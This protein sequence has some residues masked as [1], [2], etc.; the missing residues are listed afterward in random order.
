MHNNLLD[1][2]SYE[3]GN[4]ILVHH[5]LIEDFNS[6]SQLIVNESQEALFYKEGQALDLFGPGRH[7]LSTSN[8]PLLRKV[9]GALFGGNTPY[10]CDV[11][12]INKVCVMDI[13]WGTDSPIALEDPKYQLLI[14][15][16]ANGSMALYVEDSR[17]FVVN[18][19]GQLPE[20]GVDSVK[21]AIK[22]A[23]MSVIKNSIATAIASEGISILEVT[24]HLLELGEKCLGLVNKELEFFGLKLKKFYINSI[25]CPDEDLKELKEMKSKA[26]AMVIEAGAKAKSREIQGYD[27]RTERQFDVLD[28]AASNTGGAAGAFVGAGVG[29]G[30][31][32]GVGTAVSG[33]AKDAMTSQPQAAGTVKC[34]KCGAEIPA[35]AKFCPNCGQENKPQAHFC[36]NC[37]NKVEAGAKF[38]PNC[39][40]KLGE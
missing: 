30:V 29:L 7:T 28:K 38:C 21:K 27:Y 20:Y 31:G 14:N 16:R 4:D 19:V 2:I 5:S 33:V 15:V 37:G 24:T 6:K 9:V 22:G 35:S 32:V 34:A 25:S 17:R 1:V 13:M 8:L 26:T 36:P 40:Q 12:F 11:F 10:P 18:V 23:V 39:G 3:G